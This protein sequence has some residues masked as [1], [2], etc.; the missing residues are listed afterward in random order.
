MRVTARSMVSIALGVALAANGVFMLAGPNAWYAAV[1]GVVETGPFN[2]H[3]VRDIGAAY[4]ACGGAL[5]G[6]AA[7]AAARAARPAAATLPCAPAPL[8]L[9]DGPARPGGWT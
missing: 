7:G 1:P 5:G 6:Y 8:H 2:P 9:W 3:F 4:L